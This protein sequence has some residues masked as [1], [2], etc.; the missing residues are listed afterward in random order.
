MSSQA[1]LL[2]TYFITDTQADPP[3][4]PEREEQGEG[5]GSEPVNYK[6]P[7]S[8]FKENGIFS[9]QAYNVP[10]L[11]RFTEVF[12]DNKG[13]FWDTRRNLFCLPSETTEERLNLLYLTSKKG[14][15]LQD[16]PFVTEGGFTK[17]ANG[18]LS[19]IEAVHQEYQQA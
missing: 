13:V 5:S 18:V 4:S 6:N 1:C 16:Q 11:F 17:E 14:F 8:L 15:A 7:P 3:V 10:N 2:C 19:L 9:S 12:P